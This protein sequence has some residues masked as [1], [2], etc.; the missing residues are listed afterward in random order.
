M[1]C[2]Y[3]AT[4]TTWGRKSSRFSFLL[5]EDGEVLLSDLAVHYRLTAD[6]VSPAHDHNPSNSLARFLTKSEH[7]SIPGRLKIGTKNVFF[8]SDDWRD[9]IIRISFSCIDNAYL[10]RDEPLISEGVRD[11][12]AEIS[13]S[14]FPLQDKAVLV[15][16]KRAQLQR[17]NGNDHPYTDTYFS[18]V[19]SFTPSYTSEKK[20][21]EEIL[22][23]L[24][25]TSLSSRRIRDERLRDLVNNRESN[26]AFD[27]TLLQPEELEC[28]RLDSAASAIYAM[29]RG[30]GR[31]RIYPANIYFMPIHG[32][33][34]Q[35]V[36]RI[37][38]RQIRSIRRLRHGCKN[39]A[40]E[41]GYLE[42]T[43]Q[44]DG[45]QMATFMVSFPCYAVRE[46][47][48]EI[49]LV[50]VEEGVK[51]FDRRDLEEALNEW[52]AGEMS[53]FRYLMYLNMAAGR[54]YNDLSQYPVFPW[55]LTDYESEEL[56]LTNPAIFRDFS[57]PIG[58]MEPNRFAVFAERY[59]AMPQ[60]RFFYGTHYS[61]PAYTINYLVR[62][63]PA[64]MLRL[65]NGRFDH[66]DRLFHSISS[67]WNGVL[68]NQGDVKELIPEFYAI[69]SRERMGSAV[70]TNASTPG[71]F[72]ENIQGLD[73]GMRQDGKK[74]AD[75][76]LPPW[77]E[78]SPQRFIKRNREALESSHVSERLHLWIDLIFGV[79]SGNADAKN[80]F[81]TDAALPSSVE[82]EDIAKMTAEE[83]LQVE[84]V[85][86][87]F[88]RTPERLF[89]YPHPPRYGYF[90][91]DSDLADEQLE[92]SGPDQPLM[93]SHNRNTTVGEDAA[94][95]VTG[96]GE[97][98]GHASGNP[99]GKGSDSG[100]RRDGGSSW[101]PASRRRD[102]VLH[103]ANEHIIPSNEPRDEQL[104]LQKT[105]LSP[106]NYVADVRSGRKKANTI[107][108]VCIVEANPVEGTDALQNR[109]DNPLFC[110]VSL[111]GHLKIYG[112]TSIL[113]SKDLGDVC[114]FVYVAPRNIVYGTYSGHIGV[115]YI[116]TGRTEDLQRA[117]HEAEVSTLEYSEE[118]QVIVSGS[119]DASVKVWG[120]GLQ[121]QRLASLELVQELDAE[122][123]VEDLNV[124]NAPAPP[125][126]QKNDV[127]I[128]AL[129]AVATLEGS[130]VAWR[131]DTLGTDGMFPEP[132]WRTQCPKCNPEPQVIGIQ[133]D[134]SSM[135]ARHLTWLHQGSKRLPCLATIHPGDD[136][137]R[138]WSLDETNMASTEVFLSTGAT[139]CIAQ[140]PTTCTL[141]VGGA[142]GQVCE[143]D[144][145]GLPLGKVL[146]EGSE[147]CRIF[148]SQNA[149]SVYIL[150]D[151]GQVLRLN[152]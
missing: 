111:D 25:I 50:L 32:E 2:N 138:V 93:E 145:T 69:D 21:L 56:D 120:L 151:S 10:S 36:K 130:L 27:I 42:S 98:D 55:V 77:A 31:F 146:L 86:L 83:V 62:A 125:C 99:S 131:I 9:P 63:A 54:S 16:A 43:E 28:E 41:V 147:V 87:E 61:T 139:A 1:S 38:I 7:G 64:A 88:G 19:H 60:P 70:L 44:D 143:F 141:L 18:A 119:R 110:S 112:E 129:I 79:K 114:S 71:Q 97:I 37:P 15:A 113:R 116:N 5:L 76:E 84:T 106:V 123:S 30:P 80:V 92:Q 52:R 57:L 39:A 107:L 134:A 105:P 75:V 65:Q 89:K 53:N 140:A 58:A 49:L 35:A 94:C 51:C 73:L 102:S 29:A 67:T 149:M 144:G 117:A 85:Y 66:P 40:V 137:L 96:D 135:R 8:D 26:V 72:L 11:N 47:V 108:D 142:N 45:Q 3:M 148:A 46:R 109:F 68:S 133:A 136:C 24:E 95:R 126:E 23:L 78:G 150:T 22:L 13:P 82:S 17:E 20:L 118:L 12:H 6:N 115:Y 59:E 127:S 103:G 14:E 4:A 101:G 33:S 122:G 100:W 74:V 81:Y 121:K 128:Q 90:H 132:I 152:R 124:W 104:G 34:S 91:G 48:I